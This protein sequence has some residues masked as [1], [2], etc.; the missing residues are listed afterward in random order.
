M[1]HRIILALVLI[2][3]ILIANGQF[4]QNIRIQS[5]LLENG[6]SSEILGFFVKGEK[7]KH[8]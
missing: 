7:T 6:N 4:N 2:L 1:K 8:N 3:N 5:Y